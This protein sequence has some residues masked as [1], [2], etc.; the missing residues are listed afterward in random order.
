MRRVQSVAVLAIGMSCT[1][2]A[3]CGESSPDPIGPPSDDTPLFGEEGSWSTRGGLPDPLVGVAAA[4]WN[5]H[6]Y[7]I[8]GYADDT[9]GDPT[10]HVLRIDPNT[11]DVERLADFP[12][13]VAEAAAVVYR[14]T[15]LVIGGNNGD[16]IG[17]APTAGVFAYDADSDSWISR[18]TIPDPRFQHTAHNVGGVVYVVAGRAFFGAPGDSIIVL[19]DGPAVYGEPPNRTLTNPV[20]GGVIGDTIFAMSSLFQSTVVRYDAESNTWADGLGSPFEGTATGGAVAGRFHGFGNGQ[21]ADHRIWDPSTSA[22][23]TAPPPPSPVSR[24]A[25][26]GVG[27]RLFLIGG[28]DRQSNGI[29]RIQA[30]DPPN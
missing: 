25:V 3:S 6:I 1:A 10:A 18:S 23:L 24:A 20:V 16:R 14:D 4:V 28:H 27:S 12:T 30:Y 29:N 2:L 7:A 17:I 21:T 26:V 19:G 13:G 5:D 22:W 15:L 8:G 9:D 11:L